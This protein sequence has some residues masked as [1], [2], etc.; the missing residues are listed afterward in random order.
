MIE[1]CIGQLVHFS[2]QHVY[3]P[4]DHS[5]FFIEEKSAGGEGK[6]YFS[7]NSRCLI[8]KAGKQ[9]PLIWALENKKISEG[10]ILSH[11]EDGYHL[12]LLEMKSKLTVGEWAKVVEQLKGMH[13]S[14]LAV[15]RL[16]GVV[17]L[18][19]V[20][21]YVAFKQDAMSPQASAD[22]I[23]MK[24]FVGMENPLSGNADWESEA[25]ELPFTG[26]SAIVKAQRNVSNDADFGLIV[27]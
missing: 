23:L 13:L 25:L 7:A 20:T 4:E 10:A 12:H 24:T 21:C 14:A 6:S 9:G 2:D 3:E 8:F 5:R 19:S 18:A 22:M 15:L 1:S 16:L 17:E 11:N 27:S 26:T